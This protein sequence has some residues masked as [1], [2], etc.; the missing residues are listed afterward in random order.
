LA[1]SVLVHMLSKIYFIFY[2]G[3]LS[4]SDGYQP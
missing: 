3:S 1:L 4:H 2:D